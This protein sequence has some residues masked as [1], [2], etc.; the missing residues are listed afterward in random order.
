[1]NVNLN[2]RPASGFV[3]SNEAEQILNLAPDVQRN[4]QHLRQLLQTD[5]RV[6]MLQIRHHLVID[7][8]AA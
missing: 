2:L 3:S 8:T 4:Q 7:S 6:S 5:R 1:M